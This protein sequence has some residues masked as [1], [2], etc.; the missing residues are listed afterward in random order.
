MSFYT[1]LVKAHAGLRWVVLLLVLAAIVIAFQK[2][3]SRA[4]YSPTDNRVYLFALISVHIQLVLGLILYAISPKVNWN[5]LSNGVIQFYT[6]QH[7]IGMLLA[8][9]L[10]T[11][12]R[13]LSRRR[14]DDAEKH[15][16]IFVFYGIGLVLIFLFIPWSWRL[17]GAA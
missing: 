8:V 11:V 10:V 3:R 4:A 5:A 13:S 15:R 6:V 17:A 9:V 16:L 14:T 2:W 7:L 1:I 12:G